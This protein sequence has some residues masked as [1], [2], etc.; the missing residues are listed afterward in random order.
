[1]GE[2]ITRRGALAHIAEPFIAHGQAGER[3][4]ISPQAAR[5]YLH[6]RIRADDAAALPACESALGAVL[7]TQPNTMMPCGDGTLAWLGP[8]EWFV[9]VGTA[10][11]ETF[12]SALDAA[13]AHHLIAFVDLSDGRCGFEIGGMH[14]ID[15]LRKGCTL[16]L[17][18]RRFARGQC[19]R[20]SLAKAN[21]LLWPVH[22]SPDPLYGL[23]VD[24]SYADYLWHWLADAAL[25]YSEQPPA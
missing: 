20:T 25:E 21:M 2:A 14:A 5:R 16:D 13:S 6:V 10:Q 19:A 11:G 23:I 1:M 4:R 8:G 24:R 22:L 17:D 15:L 9:D 18:P 12:A 3:L 7:P